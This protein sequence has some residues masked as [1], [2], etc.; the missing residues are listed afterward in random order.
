MRRRAMEAI[1][2]DMGTPGAM[3]HNNHLHAHPEFMTFRKACE[4]TLDADNLSDAQKVQGLR[5]LFAQT[6]HEEDAGGEPA[7]EAAFE[8]SC[9]SIIADR[10]QPVDRMVTRLR[11]ALAAAGHT[12]S[13]EML[14][15]ATRA[16]VTA[17]G[18]FY[19]SHLATHGRT[20]FTSPEERAAHSREV[21]RRM[22]EPVMTTFDQRAFEAFER[23]N[24]RQREARAQRERE[25]I[26]LEGREYDGQAFAAR[27]RD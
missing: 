14:E 15:S 9:L 16:T 12:E 21:V 20:F 23:Q 22:R 19:E 17:P 18:S 1:D 13:I 26:A 25:A 5:D 7:A 2:G 10:K 6:D 11:G 4:K 3:R 27:M 8:S 24:E